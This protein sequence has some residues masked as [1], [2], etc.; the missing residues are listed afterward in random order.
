MMVDSSRQE[1]GIVDYTMLTESSFSPFCMLLPCRFA[2][3]DDMNTA[4]GS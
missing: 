2:R 3:V 4:T 1:E